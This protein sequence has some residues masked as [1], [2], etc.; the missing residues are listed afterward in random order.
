MDTDYP[1]TFTRHVIVDNLRNEIGFKGV[2]ISYDLQM[3]VVAEKYSFDT[4]INLKRKI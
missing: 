2:V 3:R 4:I 1:Y